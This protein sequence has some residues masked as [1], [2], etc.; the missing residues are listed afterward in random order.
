[1]EEK[2]LKSK[3]L[4]NITVDALKV[5]FSDALFVFLAVSSAFNILLLYYFVFLQTTTFSI[6]WDSNTTFYNVASLVL[7]LTISVLFGVVVSFLAYQLRNVKK[8]D[9]SYSSNTF[10]GAFFGALSTGC[11]VCGAFLASILGIGG[12]L[13]AFPFQ[14]LEIKLLALFL[15][16]YSLVLA[17]ENIIKK[18]CT[19]CIS[20]KKLIESKGDYVVFNFTKETLKPYKPLGV[21]VLSFFLVLALP[22]LGNKFNLSFSFQKNSFADSTSINKN[23]S[24]QGLAIQNSSTSSLLEKITPKEG[25]TINAKWGDL[26]PK[27]LASGA[28]DLEKFRRVYERSGQPLTEKQLKILT[29]G[30]DENI[31]ITKDN[32]YF[33]INFLWA[34]GLVNKNPILDNGPLSK[35]G[36]NI[37]Y[38]ASTG[39]WTLGSKKPTELYSSA[40]II[41]LNA[42]QQRELEEFANNSYRPCCNNSTAFA[43]CNHGM[44][45]LALGEIMAANGATA[46]DMFKA[47]KYF[48]AFWFPQQY[49]DLAKYFQIRE[50]K[51]WDDVDPRIVMGRNYSTASGWIRVKNYLSANNAQERLPASSAG[52]GV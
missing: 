35:Y 25:Y 2:S 10:L 19:S 15:L 5:V 50:G 14:G 9:A 27:L 20:Q 40:S 17:S 22:V 47:L 12:G 45:A 8:K 31:T 1:M 32:A 52:C 34:L 18:S 44:A 7:T 43:D 49:L 11:P 26:G 6:F 29:K 46:D 41:T 24:N 48:N 13:A 38:F 23:I 33:L 3:S 4:L 37:G 21:F 39:G 30:L 36:S 51:D 42:R 16:G 28:I